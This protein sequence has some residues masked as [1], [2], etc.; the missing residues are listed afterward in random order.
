S[1]SWKEVLA[2]EE[3]KAYGRFEEDF[4]LSNCMMSF[5]EVEVDMNTGKVDLC[6]VVNATDA[7]KII[8][9]PGLR[10]QMNG[11][12]GSAGIDSAL[13]EETVFDSNSGH[14]LNANMIDYKWRTSLELPIMDNVVLETPMPSHRFHAVG[15]GEIATSPGPS[16]ILMATANAIGCWLH[17]YPVT[18][19]K[20]L[21]ALGKVKE[22]KSKKGGV[23]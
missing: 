16:A 3:I 4:T 13:F 18:P 15:V 7:G 12:L 17:E 8:D 14:M 21:K 1:I 20:I 10:G 6:R 2:S 9:P 22:K 5:V 11:S 23:R 19:D